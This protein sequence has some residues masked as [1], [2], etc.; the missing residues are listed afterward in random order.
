MVLKASLPSPSTRAVS[1]ALKSPKPRPS[2]FARTL[3]TPVSPALHHTRTRGIQLTF[4][5]RLLFP[6]PQP[7]TSPFPAPNTSV[8]ASSTHSGIW[9]SL[10][11][12]ASA[13]SLKICSRCGSWELMT[14]CEV[15]GVEHFAPRRRLKVSRIGGFGF[16]C[17]PAA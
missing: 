1:Q 7:S 10:R 4:F 9:K 15:I 17:L 14:I 8:A 11:H 5:I 6:P 2:G 3:R 16:L 13:L 12:T